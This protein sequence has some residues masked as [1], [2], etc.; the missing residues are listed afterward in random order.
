LRYWKAEQIA[1]LIFIFSEPPGH[2]FLRADYLCCFETEF[3]VTSL[4]FR[5]PSID[6]GEKTYVDESLML[7]TAL[8]PV[9]GYDKASKI[10]H[11]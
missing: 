11:S 2:L 10:A 9:I 7:V 5:M 8:S 1:A 4:S 3:Y 6:V